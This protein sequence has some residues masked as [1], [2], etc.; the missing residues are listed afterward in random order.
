METAPNVLIRSHDMDESKIVLERMVCDNRGGPQNIDTDRNRWNKKMTKSDHQPSTMKRKSP[1]DR[2]MSEER[3]EEEEEGQFSLSEQLSFKNL[4]EAISEYQEP[5]KQRHH[6]WRNSHD[7]A[8]QERASPQL[9]R[10]T[11]SGEEPIIANK[12]P[13]YQRRNSFVIRRDNKN[14]PFPPPS[15][16]EGYADDHD[17]IDNDDGECPINRDTPD[18]SS[19][20]PADEM[21]PDTEDLGNLFWSN[22]NERE[23]YY[24]FSSMSFESAS[25]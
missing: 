22:T 13:R 1:V 20:K 3:E 18:L 5:L 4:S 8:L 23:W 24:K 9:N 25:S 6:Q 2:S 12:R 10:N 17:D 11:T 16:L 19:P 14:D 21:P 7:G 15:F